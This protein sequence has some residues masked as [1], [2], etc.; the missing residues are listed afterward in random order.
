[1]IDVGGGASTLVHALLTRGFADVTALDISAAGLG[2]VWVRVPC[3][4]SRR[5]CAP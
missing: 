1:M 5:R 2:I 3:G 4:M